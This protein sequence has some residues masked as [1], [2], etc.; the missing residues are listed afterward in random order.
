MYLFELFDDDGGM[1]EELRFMVMD[2]LTPLAANDIEWIDIS[3]IEKT[4]QDA[5]TGMVIDRG[6]IMRLIDPQVCKLVNKVEGDKVY[7]SLPVDEIAAK[8]EQDE[9]KDREHVERMATQQA[10]KQVDK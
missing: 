4:L 3:D 5:R 6:F 7:L 2:Y 8:S 10:K 9:E 1:T